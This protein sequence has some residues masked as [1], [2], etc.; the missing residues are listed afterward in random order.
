MAD[1][2]V[3]DQAYV[4]AL[5][6]SVI[7]GGAVN[8]AGQL[9]LERGNG[10]KFNA[11]NVKAGLDEYHPVGSV[12]MSFD[13][14]E[15][16]L[17]FGGGTWSR[18]KDRM[19][20]GVGDNARWNAVGEQGGAELIQLTVAEMPSH[21]HNGATH[22]AN[23]SHTHTGQVTGG[24]EHGHTYAAVA[25]SRSVTGDGQATVSNYDFAS[26]GVT[27]GGAHNHGVTIQPADMTHGHGITAS[28]G[29]NAHDNMPPFT[30]VYMWRRTE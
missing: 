10:E 11:G 3:Y 16:S 25:T 18:L 27:G 1:V 15:P 30:A 21:N 6:A 24:G 5:E 20:I 28:G 8:A 19:L 29:D 7:I 23:P 26:A 4:E 14:T 2:R 17:I 12:Y 13:A 22:D 9:V